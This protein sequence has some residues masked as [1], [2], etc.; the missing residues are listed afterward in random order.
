M[1][2]LEAMA[3]SVLISQN[4]IKTCCS[5]DSQLYVAAIIQNKA[6]SDRV[7]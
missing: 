4:G 3:V 5:S 7:S 2:G 1:A 6:V